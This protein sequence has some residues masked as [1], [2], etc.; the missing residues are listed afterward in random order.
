MKTSAALL[1]FLL[2]SCSA[3]WHLRKAISKD[4]SILTEKPVEVSIFRPEITVDSAA[5]IDVAK[6]FIVI[7]E[8]ITTTVTRFVTNTPCDTIPIPIAVETTLAADSTKVVVNVPQVVYEEKENKYVGALIWIG[9][10]VAFVYVA[11]K[12]VGRIRN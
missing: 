4:P 9:I 3:G 2:T 7:G 5:S 1:I 12:F 10:F 8:G 6:P 11:G